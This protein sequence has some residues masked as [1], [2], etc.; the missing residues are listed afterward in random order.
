MMHI[1][2]LSLALSISASATALAAPPQPIEPIEIPPSIQQ[3]VDLIY[4]DPEIAPAV[5]ERDELLQELALKEDSG[6]PLDLFLPV[7][8]VYTELRRGLVRYQ[9]KWGALPEVAIPA[10]PP[11][12]TGSTGDR[13]ALLRKRLGLADGTKY[14]A[15]VAKA[16]RLY[17]SVHALPADGVAGGGTI[18]SL[19]L[20]PA[21]YERLLMINLERARRLPRSTEQ[22]RYILVDVGGAQMYLFENG[23]VQDRMKVIVGKPET[24]TPM[25]AALIRY[26]SVNPYWNVPP[27]L[28]QNLIAPK[29]I[30]G[31]MTYLKDRGYDVLSD[32]TDEASIV[33]PETVD[34]PSVAAGKTEIRVR[35]QPGGGNSMGDIK[36][37]MP[38]DYGIYLH[39]TPNKALFSAEDRW[40]SNGCVR[41]EDAKR[42]A[43]WLFGK[44]PKGSDP[45]TEE[46][47]DLAKPVPVYITYMTAAAGGDG[48]LFRKDPYK[49]DAALL[50]RFG[51]QQEKLAQL[52]N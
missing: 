7:S 41:V 19:N 38:N 34:W 22:E 49:R 23:K 45:K 26:A 35:Q 6:A 52:S 40:V 18:E 20:G 15:E 29:V 5:R 51:D 31:G 46:K 9:M 11:L 4:I 33:D 42:L 25:M 30:A 47:V 27:E 43:T 36:F 8:P 32:W 24:A 1:R 37:M 14:D 48:V 44:M 3:G 10:G 39:D 13:V 12:K 17:Q 21:H 50:A 16:V 2:L 28:V